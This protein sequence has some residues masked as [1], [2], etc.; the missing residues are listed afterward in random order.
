MRATAPPPTPLAPAFGEALR[1]WIH[2]ALN[3]FGGPAGQIAVMHR[4]IV[5]RRG[6]LDE[7]RF[8]HALNYC[9]LLPG[10]EAQ[11]LATY[12]G[13][14]FHGVRGG[15]VAGILFVLPGVVVLM[16]LSVIYAGFHDTTLVQALF[17]G[18][19][20][21][22]IAVVAEAA[23]RLARRALKGRAHVSIAIGAFVAIFFFDIPFPLVIVGA[24]IAGA[25]LLRGTAPA[26]DSGTRSRRPDARRSVVAALVGLAL[27][28]TPTA[29]AA[30]LAGPT[31]IYTQLA[32]FFSFAAVITFGG[33]YA[34]LA[35][36]AQQA[37][38]V[39]GWLTA[40]Q[41]VDGLGLAESTPG[42]LIMVVQFVGFMAAFGAAGGS[43]AGLDPFVAGAVGGLLVTWVTFVPSLTFIF[44]GAPYA[45]YLRERPGLAAALAG[46]SAAVVGVIANLAVFFALNT[47]FRVNGEA[48]IGILRIH[49]VDVV[50]LD[51]F[52]L[53][54]AVAS[55]VCLTRLRWPLLLTLALSA[56][57][58]LAYF[59]V[60]HPGA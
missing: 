25:M 11:Q 15:L 42:P 54:L 28:L 38:D 34:I 40:T 30:V 50:S 8:L 9:M 22:V 44:A 19:K 36:I 5:E 4:E 2:V 6:W 45:E 1:T 31:S 59:L 7:R 24:G 60:V 17:Y 41:M 56:A 33:A 26:S 53:V 32:L 57:A 16:A 43:E 14:L 13:W 21:A 37:V 55:Y 46:V 52:A 47:L 10:P 23:A 49:T 39:F 3:S 12:I 51:A 20:P 27:W 58:G 48:T 29:A 35:F 18:I